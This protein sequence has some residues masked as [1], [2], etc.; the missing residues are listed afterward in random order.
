MIAM[1]FLVDSSICRRMVVV[2]TESISGST[3][4]LRRRLAV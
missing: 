4:T 1:I 3:D 2:K